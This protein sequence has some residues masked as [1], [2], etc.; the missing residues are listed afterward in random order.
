MDNVGSTEC[1]VESPEFVT[2]DRILE[3]GEKTI[4]ALLELADDVDKMH[5]ECKISH[6]VGKGTTVVGNIISIAGAITSL[7]TFGI[8]LPLVI[9]G[10]AI[11]AAGIATTASTKGVKN[12]LNKEKIRKALDLLKNHS[13]LLKSTEK[14]KADAEGVKDILDKIQ[15]TSKMV[16]LGV[17][18]FEAAQAAESGNI[19]AAQAAGGGGIEAAQVAGSG[20][21]EAAQ[22]AG[23]GVIES[24]QAAGSGGIEIARSGGI[25]AA[26]AA[27][28]GNIE[29]AQAA[30][31]GGIEAAQAVGSGG[32]EVAQAAGS[33]SIEVAQAVG[34]GGIEVAQAIGSGGV[35]VAQIAVDA[36]SNAVQIA[37]VGLIGLASSI[38]I[39]R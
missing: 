31:T 6:V 38:F 12:M 22:A 32:I 28:S 26:Q 7:V 1:L 10:P 29:A 23:I 30:G 39:V 18:F 5:K 8:T 4:K 9:T 16:E 3:S 15:G 11:S 13:H 33:G 19:A 24:A 35:E 34:N 17:K 37:G 25:D 2:E 20:V 36:T 27:G 14:Y 21:I